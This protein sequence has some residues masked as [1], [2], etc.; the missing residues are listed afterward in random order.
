MHNVLILGCGRSGTSIFGELFESNYFFD[1]MFEPSVNDVLQNKPGI[2]RRTAAKVPKS[3]G[4][5]NSP[6]L[7]INLEEFHKKTKADYKYI[8]IVRHPLDTICSLKPGIAENWSHNP[9]PPNYRYLQKNKSLAE[10]C[11]FHWDHINR[12][13]LDSMLSIAGKDNV[14]IVKYEEFVNNPKIEAKKYIDS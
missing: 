10:C 5:D 9:K 4:K 2:C 8:F 11:A 3:S 12:A 1:Y 6:G 7:S 13:G 14:L